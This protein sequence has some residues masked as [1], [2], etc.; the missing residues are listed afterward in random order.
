MT[1]H[2]TTHAERELAMAEEIA[3]RQWWAD[4]VKQLRRQRRLTQQVLADLVGCSVN[5]VSLWETGN[6]VADRWVP[7]IEAV[8]G[9]VTGAQVMPGT[10]RP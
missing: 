7:L 5:T 8:E 1:T 10:G 6:G 4:R 9:S 3:E 2:M